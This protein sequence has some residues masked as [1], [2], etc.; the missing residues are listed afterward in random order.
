MLSLD[1]VAPE[2]SETSV[3]FDLLESL[4]VLSQLSVQLIAN[5]LGV[6]TVL[7]V[8]LSVEE[9]LGNVVFSGSSEDVVDFLK[10][11]FSEFTSSFVQV[12][13]SN[14]ENDVGEA[15]SDTSDNSECEHNLMLSFDVS[16]EDS[17][18]VGELVGVLKDK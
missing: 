6:N 3:V 17:Q 7:G 4:H 13:L 18:N 9:P 12:H 1:F 5:N 8:S 16:V 2:V 15:T 11:G 14:L 10:L